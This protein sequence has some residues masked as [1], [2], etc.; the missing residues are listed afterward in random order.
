MKEIYFIFKKQLTTKSYCL[1]R[2]LL[3]LLNKTIRIDT[4][5]LQFLLF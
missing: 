4:S 1:N 5:S 2:A 3:T